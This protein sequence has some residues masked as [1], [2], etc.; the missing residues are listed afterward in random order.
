MILK[1]LL[2]I[3]LIV[4]VVSCNEKKKQP[5]TITKVQGTEFM[6]RT[7]SFSFVFFTGKHNN[8]IKDLLKELNYQLISEEVYTGAMANV[9]PKLE[10]TAE[11]NKVVKKGL[12]EI[13]NVTILVDPEMV[14]CTNEDQLVEFAKTNDTQ[15]LVAIWERYSQTRLLVEIDKEGVKSRTYAAPE[16]AGQDN[17]NPVKEVLESSSE[18]GL[19]AVLKTRGL[20]FEKL[21]TNQIS[22]TA[23]VLRE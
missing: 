16:S 13:D 8:E 19:V 6:E 23:L 22:A 20:P 11:N 14:I 5:E 3:L 4:T 18:S 2:V 12:V 21:M 15:I 7:S 1:Q 10:E 17:I 9:Y